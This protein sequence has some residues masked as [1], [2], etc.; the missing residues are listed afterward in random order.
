MVLL[1]LTFRESKIKNKEQREKLNIWFP[2]T[3]PFFTPLHTPHQSSARRKR[4][5]KTKRSTEIGANRNTNSKIKLES[6]KL[7]ER[8]DQRR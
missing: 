3:K 6:A 8:H 2:I 7:G 1:E 5:I 4:K